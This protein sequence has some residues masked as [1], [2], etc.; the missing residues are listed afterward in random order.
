MNG[1][2]FVGGKKYLQMEN[3]INSYRVNTTTKVNMIKVIIAINNRY[4]QYMIS[5]SSWK[6]E[7]L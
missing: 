2:N 5:Y 7:L 6:Y 1:L 3:Y 4:Q